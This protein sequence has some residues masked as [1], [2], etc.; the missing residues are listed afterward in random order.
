MAKKSQNP[1]I[2]VNR[3]ARRDYEVLERIEAGIALTGTEVKSVRARNVDLNSGFADVQKGQVMLRDAH[4]KPYEF[5]HQ[6]NHEPRRPRRL[7]LHRKEIDKLLG[8]LTAKGLTLI[9]LSI[10]FNN[11]G[12]VKVELGLCRGKQMGDKREILRR[13]AADEDTARAMAFRRGG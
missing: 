1:A 11:R 8:K 2:A 12:L 4:I 9:P 13:K 7:L 6:S 5:G 10:Y 3:N